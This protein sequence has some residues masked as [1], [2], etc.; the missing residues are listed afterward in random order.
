M[1]VTHIP[2]NVF[3]ALACGDISRTH[4]AVLSLMHR[5][6]DY[7]T[8]KITS[9]SAARVLRALN[10]EIRVIPRP[11]VSSLLAI[12]FRSAIAT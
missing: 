10:V 3:D 2:E 4:F 1:R 9:F 11:K 8:G 7:S 6:A 5:W 12:R